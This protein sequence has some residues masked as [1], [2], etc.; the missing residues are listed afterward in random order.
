M[1][2]KGFSTGPDNVRTITT[3]PSTLA[4]DLAESHSDRLK[5]R[6]GHFTET[7]LIPVYCAALV[8]TLADG[9][10]YNNLLYTITDNLKGTDKTVIFKD[11]PF[12]NPAPDETRVFAGIDRSDRDKMIDGICSRI[13][14][15][16]DSLRTSLASA[17]FR[18]MLTHSN[19]AT[20]ILFNHAVKLASWFHRCVGVPQIKNGIRDIPVMLY[21]GNITEAELKVVHMLCCSGFDAIVISP[22]KQVLTLINEGNFR[23]QMQVFELEASAPVQPYP[24]KLLKAKVSTV[25]YN[26]ERELDDILYG[27]DTMFRDFQFSDL[28][29]N[30]LR[31]TYDEI[32][33]LWHTR[34]QY[35]SGFSVKNGRVNVPVFFAK[36]DG[37]PDGDLSAYWE[38]IREKLSPMTL[39]TV[40][41]P[42]YDGNIE[43]QL[44]K[45]DPYHDGHH[46]FAEKLK[47]SRMN[48][49]GFLSDSL[50][51]LIIGKIQ[52]TF[53]SGY[54]LIDDR[55]CLAQI[56]FVAMNL[57]R[58]ILRILQKYDFTK[59]IPKFIVIDA[60]EDTFSM[61]ECIQLV[62]LSMLGFDI[63]VYAPTGY[64]DLETFVSPKAYENHRMNEFKYNVTVPRF[65]IPDKIPQKK[66]GLFSNLFKKGRK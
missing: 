53:D 34:S 31:T 4:D 33:V 65:K 54:L 2:F 66:S 51:Q 10:Q 30:V 46:V 17:A 59:D 16:G 32:D 48:N 18:D 58:N 36:I 11:T 28:E 39:L 55:E 20:G 24:T 43:A 5:S 41:A 49:Y 61:R 64:R 7:E 26:A 62:F 42:S 3:D 22:D 29:S 19:T 14:V 40:K 47:G 27:S 57:D 56:M 8:G 23:S 21:Y 13:S 25:A 45:F 37:V 63:L 60:I 1:N 50:Q 35:R 9:D 38:S 52:E 44:H 12:A 6:G 15:P